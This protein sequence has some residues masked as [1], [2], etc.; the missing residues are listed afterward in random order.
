MWQGAHSVRKSTPH[1]LG[2]KF[3]VTSETLEL[4]CGKNQHGR[5]T[6]WESACFASTRRFPPGLLETSGLIR[7]QTRRL[8]WGITPLCLAAPTALGASEEFQIGLQPRPR[9]NYEYSTSS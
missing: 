9:R 3:A 5:V 4:S 8:V 6:Q 7:Q 1:V 2:L